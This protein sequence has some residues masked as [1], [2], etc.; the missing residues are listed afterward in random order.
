[1]SSSDQV[2]AAAGS[3]A[4]ATPAVG[5]RRAEPV[6]GAVSLTAAAATAPPAATAA[7]ATAPPAASVVTRLPVTP[8]APAPSVSVVI[9]AYTMQRWDL[10]RRAIASVQRQHVRPEEIILCI[11]HNEELFARCLEEWPP[12]GRADGLPGEPA[13]RVVA[14]RFEGRLG[15]ARNTAVEHVTADVVAFL[16]D[17]AAAEPDWLGRLLQAYHE[18]GAHAV[19]GAPLPTF[20]TGRPDWFPREFDWVFG[21]HYAGLPEHRAPA[22]HLIGA[23]MS[24]RTDALRHVGGFHSDN[25]DDMDM[26]H[27]IAAA[28]GPRSVVYEPRAQ[29]SHFVTAERVTWTYFWRRCFFVNRGKVRAFADMGEAGNITAELNFA[30]RMVTAVLSRVRAGLTGEP[31]AFAQAGAIVAGVGLAGLGHVVGTAELRLGLTPPSRTRGLA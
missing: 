23:A 24:A 21:C 1:M 5:L 4:P 10:L 25:H 29:V 27:R 19:G 28:Y 18:S 16:D 17:D 13:V 11:D 26:C 3:P 14:N 7:A 22:R 15:S 9:C 6:V 2:D 8:P 30:K 31:G 20:E 12:G